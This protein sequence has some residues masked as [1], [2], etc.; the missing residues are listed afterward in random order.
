MLM[1]AVARSEASEKLETARMAMIL[2][3]KL[4]S[5]RFPV[6]QADKERKRKGRSNEKSNEE[7]ER[8]GQD[9]M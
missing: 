8:T 4:L 7:R 2:L 3:A 1:M 6:R 5:L 9:E